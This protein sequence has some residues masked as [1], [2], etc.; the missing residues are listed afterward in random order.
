MQRIPD[1]CPV[2]FPS[3]SM[4]SVKI[5]GNIIELKRPTDKMAI[6]ETCPVEKIAASM[7]TITAHA[8]KVR[9]F[10]GEMYLITAEPMNLPTIA[11]P[12]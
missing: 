9:I 6:I 12:Q 8:L 1:A 5:V 10:A 2:C 7:R 11:L 4:A 3:P